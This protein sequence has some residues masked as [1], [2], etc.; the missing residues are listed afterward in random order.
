MSFLLSNYKELSFDGLIAVNGGCNN[1]LANA[2]VAGPA[3]YGGSGACAFVAPPQPVIFF[4]NGHG[5][6]PI[7]Y[8]ASLK[9]NI[10]S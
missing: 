8:W 10:T 1:S 5:A 7:G 6:D 9:P 2:H 4:G 3:S